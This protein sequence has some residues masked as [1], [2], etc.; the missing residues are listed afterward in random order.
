MIMFCFTTHIFNFWSKAE[1]ETFVDF[2]EDEE[3]Y[4]VVETVTPQS[5]SMDE[6]GV[7]IKYL[8]RYFIN[9]TTGQIEKMKTDN[10]QENSINYNNKKIKIKKNKIINYL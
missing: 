4:T 5:I 8:I 1:L 9:K 10:K 2:V 3:G 6:M 7:D